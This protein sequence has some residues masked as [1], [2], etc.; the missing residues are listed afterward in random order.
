MITKIKKLYICYPSGNINAIVEDNIPKRDYSSVAERIINTYNKNKPVEDQVEQVAFIDKPTNKK[1]ISSLSLSGN[2]FSGNAVLCLGTLKLK[3]KKEGKFQISGSK[4]IL[5][6]FKD[7]NGFINGK[8]PMFEFEGKIN[9]TKEGYQIIPL[10]GITQI[11]VFKNFDKN[12]LWLKNE[13]QKIIK[14]NGLE[15]SLAVVIDFINKENNIFK[16]KPYVYFRKGLVYEL[17][18]ETACGS[19]TTAIGIYLSFLTNKSIQ[20]QK[21][22]QPSGDSLYI[23][24]GKINNQ[25]ESY[26]SGKVKILYQGPF[27]LN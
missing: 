4:Q 19:A 9:Q 7:D 23:S 20:Y 12:D 17:V 22:V 8:M 26:L 25:F 5:K 2:E 24:V 18:R 14:N 11:L 13:A 1:A 6:I 27:D 21:V 15:K 3:N 16:I 10:Q